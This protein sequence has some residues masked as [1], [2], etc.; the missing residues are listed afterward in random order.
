[1]FNT[2]FSF[3]LYVL[4]SLAFFLDF[5]DIM[6]RLYLRRGQ[7][8]PLTRVQV[9]PT[10]VP[11]NVGE[12]TPYEVR[13]HLRPYAI[14]VSVHNAAAELDRF[15]KFI[16]PFREHVWVIDDASDDD[17]WAR[18][19][20][21]GVKCVQG[22]RNRHKPGAIRT[23]LTTLPPEIATVIVIDPDSRIITGLAEVEHVLFEFQRSEMAALCPR[24]TIRPDGW[25]TRIQRL[26][27]WL[28]FSLGRKS[29]A[30]CSITSGIAVY[31]RDALQQVFE[32]HS[33]SVYAEDLEN[34][35]ILLSKNERV[36]Y[37]GR[38]VVETDGMREL[39]RLFSQRV[40]WHFGLIKVYVEHWRTIVRNTR[41]GFVFRY[42]FLVYMGLFV[43]MLH[44]LKLLS[45]PLV[46]LSALNGLDSLAGQ[47]LVPDTALTNPVYF[48]A[49]YV[50][51][52]LLILFVIPLAVGKKDRL[53]VLPVVPFYVFYALGQIV[54]ATVG[55]ANWFAVRIWGRRVYRDHYQPAQP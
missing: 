14:L 33:L 1:M 21:A 28:A 13:F 53:A 4:G 8:L 50:K 38:L 55:Y 3:S 23:L 40:G 18:L 10:S 16:E 11:L 7:T 12:F 35:L 36:Y 9:P 45:L 54:P 5:I 42:Q 26:E 41:P 44:P 43:L 2:G 19:C 29:L 22:G 31:R 51:Y 52:S 24:I 46:I 34:A 49:L 20:R 32:R 37:D 48:G 39:R 27:Y 6:V 47:N 17:T 30:D 25:L 15:L